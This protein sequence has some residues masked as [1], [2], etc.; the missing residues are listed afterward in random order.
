MFV[1]V[2]FWNTLCLNILNRVSRVIASKKKK[3]KT[4]VH[5]TAS[6]P[7]FRAK[8]LRF[9]VR[10]WDSSIS[11]I[12]FETKARLPGRGGG[13]SCE[14]IVFDFAENGLSFEIRNGLW[15]KSAT[16]NQSTYSKHENVLMFFSFCYPF[17][18]RGRMERLSSIAKLYSSEHRLLRIIRSHLPLET[19][20]P[21]LIIKRETFV[22][23]KFLSSIELTFHSII[24]LSRLESYWTT[25]VTR[26]F[27]ISPP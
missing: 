7:K 8:E 16:I 20:Y 11:R 18:I 14:E 1:T 6:V 25:I 3:V 12:K 26:S 13:I 19:I 5:F 24:Q 4:K 10:R 9:L 21:V 22:H 27:L 17:S 2:F 23:L 15:S